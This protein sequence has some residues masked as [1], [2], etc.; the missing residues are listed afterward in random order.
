MISYI[1]GKSRMAKWISGYIPND[2]ETYVEVFGG[3]FWV[4][5]NGDVHTRPNLKKVIYNDFNR[6]M[7]NLF[8][9]C[10]S[11]KEF[12]DFMLDIISQNE[13]LF[14]QYKKEEFEDNNVNDVTL[15][16]MNF[17]MK[18]AYIVT[19]VFSGLNP[20]KSKFI[21]LKGKYKSKFDSFRG[22]LVN[23]KFTEKLKLIDTC[24]N[25]DYSE[26]I[27]KY[28][29]PTTYF[30]V[31]PPYWKTENYYS[32]HDF[33]RE[34][35]EKLCMQ[36]KNIEGRFSLSYYDFELLGEWL[37]ESEFTWVRK[38]FVK[39]ASARK[40]TKQNKGEELLIMNYKLNR[41]F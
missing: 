20:E 2:I 6:Y 32:L 30:Y 27:E 8:E 13:D 16:D 19:Q 24:E 36:L 28:D 26:V 9:C 10:K 17:A 37:P 39:A 29:S 40:D 1:G 22:R 23:P 7:V 31:D 12:H 3:A 4:Y 21:N 5:V 33:D 11:P 18:Y 15:G 34:D 41:F 38:E 14:Y 35:H 25:M